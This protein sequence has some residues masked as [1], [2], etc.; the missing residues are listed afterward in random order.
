MTR[1][2]IQLLVGLVIFGAGCALMVQAHIGLDP[3]TVFA[4][5]IALQT[6]IGIGWVT[7]IIGAVVLLLWIP[8][9]QRPGIG[10]LANIV[11][12]G[13]SMQL[14]LEVLP[15]VEGWLAQAGMFIAGLLCVA[16]ASGLYIG[17]RFGPGPRDGLMTGLHEKWGWPIW[18]S[19]FGVE[20]S[21]LVAGWLLGGT[22]GVGTVLFA[23][24]IGPLVQLALRV[25]D[26]RPRLATAPE[27]GSPRLV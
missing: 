15:D 16:V 11:L 27:A 20:A 10:T 8:L 22:V 21:V 24:S 12:V 23:V 26:T 17:A 14:T 18:V 2:V 19:R 1:R 5:G 13:T 3:W 9:R 25:F 6:G 4:Q 7:I